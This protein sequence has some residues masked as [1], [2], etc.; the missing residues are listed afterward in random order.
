MEPFKEQF[1]S[2][3]EGAPRAA[4]KRLTQAIKEQLIEATIN[5][6]DWWV[7]RELSSMTCDGN[8]GLYSRDTLYAVRI[9]RDILWEGEKEIELEDFVMISQT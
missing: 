4:V 8:E 7:W 9:A 6:P 2:S 1:C 5:A 3:E